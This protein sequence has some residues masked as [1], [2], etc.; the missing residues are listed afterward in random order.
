MKL[1]FSKEKLLDSL[2]QVQSVVS[3]RST[4]PIL[5]NTLLHARRFF[6]IVRE[7][8]QNEISMEVDERNIAAIQS[9]GS[10]FKIHGLA[11]TEFPQAP[12]LSGAKSFTLEQKILRDALKKTSYAMSGDETRYVLNGVLLRVKEDKLIAI[13]T[14]GRRLALSEYYLD[15]PKDVCVEL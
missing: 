1:I 10:L 4:L 9:G 8:T 11:E 6:S 12:K 14:D 7:L 5:S 3:V 15:L 13:A 2:Q